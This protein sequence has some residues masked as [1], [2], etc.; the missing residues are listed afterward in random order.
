MPNNLITNKM[1]FL[2]FS[3]CGSN[4][5]K[6]ETPDYFDDIQPFVPPINEGHVIK[7]YD[8]DTIT[9]VSKLPYSGSPKYKFSVRLAGIDSAEMSSKNVNEKAKAIEARDALSSKIMGKNVTLTNV[10]TEKYGRILADV[11]LDGLHLNEWMIKNGF[12]VPYDGGAKS[13]HSW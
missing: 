11:H 7:V 12:A 9:I 5:P 1:K 2:C 6:N 8:G 3:I 13:Q 4:I 10:K